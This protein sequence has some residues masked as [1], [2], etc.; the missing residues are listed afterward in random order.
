MTCKIGLAIAARYSTQNGRTRSSAEVQL[1]S[2]EF[3]ELAT[4]LHEDRIPFVFDAMCDRIT[5]MLE[6]YQQLPESE[7]VAVQAKF[8]PKQAGRLSY[9]AW[10]MAEDGVRKNSTQS[11]KLGLLAAALDGGQN[12]YRNTV[13]ILCML[14]HT[15]RK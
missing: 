14:H 6:H 2:L 11:I 3:E 1:N 8:G 12:D 10:K 9:Y 7:R 4:L 13:P 5:Q 15:Q